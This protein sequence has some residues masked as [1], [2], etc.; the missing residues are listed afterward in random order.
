MRGLACFVKL[1]VKRWIISPR[2]FSQRLKL[3]LAPPEVLI[4]DFPIRYIEG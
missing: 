3:L 1:S 2:L 4:H